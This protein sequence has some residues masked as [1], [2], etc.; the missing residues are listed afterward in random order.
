[1]PPLE[2]SPL[3]L[4]LVISI[5]GSTLLVW[6]RHGGM[7]WMFALGGFLFILGRVMIAA[8]CAFVLSVIF[9]SMRDRGSD[10][11]PVG[12]TFAA[13]VL[14]FGG[15]SIFVIVRTVR[16]D[17]FGATQARDSKV[18]YTDRHS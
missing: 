10:V 18:R 11:F 14:A 15:W 7:R 13:A 17:A 5:L 2:I 6:H 12:A 1:M 4:A 16:R 3:L 9:E 8:I